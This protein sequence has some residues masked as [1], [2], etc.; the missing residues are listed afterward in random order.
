MSL[1]PKKLRYFLTVID[2]GS[3]TRAARELGVSQSTLSEH[4][5]SLEVQLG[6]A[7]LTRGLRG[8][9]V[10]EAGRTLYRH[11]QI[12]VRQ[13]EQAEQ[14][15]TLVSNV[16]SG[17]VSLGLATYGAASTLALPILRR[18]TERCPDLLLRVNDN[19]AGILSESIIN[20]RIDI[21]I[22]YGVGPIK[23]VRLRTLFVEELFLFAHEAAT[24]PGS[25]GSDVPL[26]GLAGMK[27]LLP[28]RVHLLRQ[29]ID[30]GFA[31]A[32][33][34]PDIVAEVDSPAA[35]RDALR[36]NLGVAL[37][38]DS[39]FPRDAGRVGLQVRPIR[40][41]RLEATVALCM[42]EQWPITNSVRAIE[43]VIC[44]LVS[45]ALSE[46]WWTGVRPLAGALSPG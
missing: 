10:T 8:V 33:I 42:S 26:A 5:A 3:Y 39:A 46:G 35:L 2:R 1:D 36:G 25:P 37:L 24:I 18:V 14:D 13:V 6:R 4:I 9:S 29:V 32:G 22:I 34:H 15:I 45:E 44:Q 30:S 17:H 40:Q 43:D 31:R 20:G 23:G 38:P 28:S 7:L 12:I 16:V 41:P 21:A 11:A 27:L 19:F